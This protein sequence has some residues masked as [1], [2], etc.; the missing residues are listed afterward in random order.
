MSLDL[1]RARLTEDDLHRSS[2][3]APFLP[4]HQPGFASNQTAAYAW[5]THSSKHTPRK[6]EGS[7]GPHIN[8]HTASSSPKLQK[9]VEP[10]TPK[11]A[12]SCKGGGH[13]HSPST[14]TIPRSRHRSQNIQSEAG[15]IV[16][17]KAVPFTHSNPDFPTPFKGVRTHGSVQP[18]PRSGT[19][20]N[21][22]VRSTRE[23]VSNLSQ[24]VLN[25]IFAH[26]DSPVSFSCVCRRFHSTSQ[27]VDAK[28]AFFIQRYG[29][30]NAYPG[31]LLG[32]FHRVAD[33]RLLEAL[34]R[35]CPLPRWIVQLAAID[36]SFR[37]SSGR[38]DLAKSVYSTALYDTR[39]DLPQWVEAWSLDMVNWLIACGLD[40][41]GPSCTEGRD[42]E[43]VQNILADAAIGVSLPREWDRLQCLVERYHYSPWSVL[44]DDQIMKRKHVGTFSVRL[45][46]DIERSDL[47]EAALDSHIG[48][49]PMSHIN[50]LTR[51][52]I[53]TWHRLDKHLTL[54]PLLGTRRVAA[55]INDI[56]MTEVLLNLSIPKYRFHMQRQFRMSSDIAWR[57]LEQ[58]QER[59][60]GDLQ[61]QVL[62]RLIRVAESDANT[63]FLENVHMGAGYAV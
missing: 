58:T 49:V 37:R 53:Q 51:T 42:W 59:G 21:Q 6:G 41:Y 47:I 34:L 22:T 25:L 12:D 54:I 29:K 26:L 2:S 60:F 38:Q 19:L 13:Y 39:K 16:Q 1:E 36:K 31:C 24:R 20:N 44:E 63:L 4:G 7:N 3:R 8:A 15:H 50:A 11:A 61:L 27:S 9:G 28:A 5:T 32:K 62:I 57:A 43:D 23:L 30:W 40:L 17:L 52:D 35:T 45:S 18:S 33:M 48:N 55:V 46:L 56:V 10:A 14:F